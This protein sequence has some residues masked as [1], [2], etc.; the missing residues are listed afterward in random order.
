MFSEEM[1]EEAKATL[2][3][4]L[5]KI[6]LRSVRDEAELSGIIRRGIKNYIFKATKK[7][8]MILPVVM[9]V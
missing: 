1:I 9:V 7:N 6:D 3:A 4:T 2:T 5:N 8:P